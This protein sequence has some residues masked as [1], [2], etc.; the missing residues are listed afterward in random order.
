MIASE[1]GR[2]ET[3]TDFLSEIRISQML[4]CFA[5]PTKIRVIADL[6]CDV[7]EAMPYLATLLSKAGYNHAASILTFVRDGRLFSVYQHVVT[8][9]KAADEDDARD[10]LEWLRG[11]IN[12]AYARRKEIE[13]CLERRRSPRLL[14]V[15]RLLPHDNCG[16][17]GEATCLA[18]A[19]KLIFGPR[20][21]EHCPRL[22]ES[23]FANN[24]ALL[25]EWLGVE[26]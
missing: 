25:T 26:A 3:G 4:E 10:V 9:A 21:L 1:K 19:C 17:C 14:D 11:R 5:D 15:Y 20:R 2:M 23:E 13:P 8:L 12:E 6:S 22:I 16:R 18:M 24:R 7:R